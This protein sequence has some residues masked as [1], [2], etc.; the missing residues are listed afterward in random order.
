MHYHIEEADTKS[1]S[2]ASS[3]NKYGRADSL[4]QRQTLFGIGNPT[5]GLFYNQSL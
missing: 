1:A 2:S 3:E 5:M 4:Q